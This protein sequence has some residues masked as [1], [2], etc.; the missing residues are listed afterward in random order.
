VRVWRS[1]EEI[2]TQDAM[3]SFAFRPITDEHPD[4][5]VTAANWRK[6][7]A[8][9]T[10][11]EVIKDSDG[12]VQ[13]IRVPL[14]LM[15]AGLIKKVKDGKRELSMG[16]ETELLFRDGITPQGESYDAIQTD[17]RANHLAVVSTARGGEKLRIG[18]GKEKDAMTKT[19]M[20]DGLQVEVTD[21][22]EAAII[23][24]QGTIKTLTDAAVK[25]DAT[26][27]ANTA[28]LNDALIKKDAEIAVL[29]TQ[30]MTAD[31][32]DRAIVTRSKLI[33]DAQRIHPQVKVESVSDADIRKAAVTAKLGD[34]AVAGKEQAFFDHVF[35]ALVVQ[36]PTQYIPTTGDS[37]TRTLQRDTGVNL[38]D[39]EKARLEAEDAERNAWK[40]DAKKKYA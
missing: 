18:D 29:K 3:H 4:T 40:T 25:A 7:A 1:P 9:S 10:G 5:K 19:I 37:F 23:K 11:P 26:T 21:A 27:A 39:S 28:T 35:D 16:Y 17:I 6:L 8:G 32:L 2:Y 34:A 20:V 15:D 14:V 33:T 24:L 30:V 36:L 13:Y 38:S 22:A 12:Q 31:L